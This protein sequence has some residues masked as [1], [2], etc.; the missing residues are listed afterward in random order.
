KMDCAAPASFTHT[1]HTRY[2][3]PFPPS[4]GIGGGPKEHRSLAFS[5]RATPLRQPIRIG[6]QWRIPREI[7]TTFGICNRFGGGGRSF[8]SAESDFARPRLV[9][10]AV[11]GKLSDACIDRYV[12]PSK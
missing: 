9:R 8:F 11:F 5:R 7:I 1:R 12:C 6:G 3:S 4:E 10:R 2:A